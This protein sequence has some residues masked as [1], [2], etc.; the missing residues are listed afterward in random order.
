MLFNSSICEIPKSPSFYFY[1]I[2]I[3]E[4]TLCGFNL[5]KMYWG[6]MAKCVVRTGW[7]VS[8]PCPCLFGNTVLVDVIKMQSYWTSRIGLAAVATVLHHTCR[9]AATQWLRQRLGWWSVSQGCPGA[10]VTARNQKERGRI[11]PKSLRSHGPVATVISDFLP[12]QPWGSKRL[13]L[14]SHQVWG[15]F[16]Q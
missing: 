7:I 16:L 14:L 2:V 12:P 9:E 10:L 4:D 1:S 11:F 13:N 8:P 6:F 5:L 3:K 15:T